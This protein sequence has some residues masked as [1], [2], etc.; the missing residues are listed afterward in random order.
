MGNP[1][2]HEDRGPR[3]LDDHHH[4]GT[5]TVAAGWSQVE[6]VILIEFDLQR[7]VGLRHLNVM[8]LERPDPVS[9]P[10]MD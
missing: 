3:I 1:V 6:A 5:D 7:P 4:E 8:A 2:Q 9:S 10:A